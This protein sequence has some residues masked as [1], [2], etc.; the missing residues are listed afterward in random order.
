MPEVVASMPCTGYGKGGVMVRSARTGLC[1]GV[2]GTTTRGTCVRPTAMGRKGQG[3]RCVRT[4]GG[5]PGESAPA[6]PIV[7]QDDLL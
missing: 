2:L 3:G 4:F 7:V 5:C 6:L 1:E